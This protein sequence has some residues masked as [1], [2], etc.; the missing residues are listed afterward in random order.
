MQRIPGAPGALACLIFQ[1]CCSSRHPYRS[2]CRC[3]LLVRGLYCSQMR[4]RWQHMPFSEACSGSNSWLRG[5]GCLERFFIPFMKMYLPRREAK[6]SSQLS[7]KLSMLSPHYAASAATYS[8]LDPCSGRRK[9]NSCGSDKS[10]SRISLLSFFSAMLQRDAACGTA[11][12]KVIHQHAIWL[13]YRP[14]TNS[15][16]RYMLR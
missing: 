7:T 6:I 13:Q 1:A 11:K 16:Q 15:R 3:L 5:K 2:M 4:S 10:R 8:A 14:R 9:N 12:C